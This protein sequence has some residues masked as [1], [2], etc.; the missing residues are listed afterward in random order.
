M[1]A[2]DPALRANRIQRLHGGSTE[3]YRIDVDGGEPLVLKLYGEPISWLPRKEQLAVGWFAERLDFATPRWLALDESRELLPV[4]YALT[5]FLAGGAVADLI[6]KVDLAD[7]YRQMGALLRRIHAIP[8]PAYGYVTDI[9]IVDPKPTNA[10]YMDF[11]FQEAFDLFRRQGGDADLAG[12]LERI[13]ADRAAL[14]ASAG[15][16]LCH[17]DFHQ[18]NLL[19]IRDHDGSPRLCG[20]LDFGNVRAADPVFDLAK[21]L[22]IMAHQDPDSRE[23]F[24]AGYGPLDHPD[25]ERALWLYT[26]YHRVM[27]WSWLRRFGDSPDALLEDLKAMAR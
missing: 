11:A 21:T 2:F 8:M 25:P 4:R 6:G 24:L 1:T 12:R 20:L 19:A 18:A 10:A 23:P 26:L 22:F 5:T 9:G 27:M 16:V 17:D 15:P 13:A 3:V 7:I 14:S